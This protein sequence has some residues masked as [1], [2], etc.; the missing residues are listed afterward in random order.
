MPIACA[1]ARGSILSSSLRVCLSLSLRAFFH[2]FIIFL[3]LP[4]CKVTRT[5]E[6]DCICASG[7]SVGVHC[8]RDKRRSDESA[9]VTIFSLIFR[10][11]TADTYETFDDREKTCV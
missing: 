2:T 1:N 8:L 4:D 9:V 11:C 7:S 10:E 3:D 6:P 5:R